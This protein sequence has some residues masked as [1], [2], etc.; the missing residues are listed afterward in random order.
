MAEPDDRAVP[1]LRLAQPGAGRAVAVPAVDHG[2]QP[3]DEGTDVSGDAGGAGTGDEGV[4]EVRTDGVLPLPLAGEGW[5]EGRAYPMKSGQWYASACPHPL[6][7]SRKRERGA[8]RRL[9]T[10]LSS[11][12]NP[13]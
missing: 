9:A 6:P 5:G 2:H 3:A 10:P 7:L 11:C 1:A 13:P 4:V 8:N 12:I